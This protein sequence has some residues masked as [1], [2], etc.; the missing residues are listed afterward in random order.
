M[1]N[2][3]ITIRWKAKLKLAYMM[4]DISVSAIWQTPLKRLTSQTRAINHSILAVIQQYRPISYIFHFSQNIL[5]KFKAVLLFVTCSG[6]YCCDC[7][8]IKRFFFKSYG[9]F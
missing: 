3:F 1:H 6:H 4:T 7:I 8:E 9:S 2:F 5:C